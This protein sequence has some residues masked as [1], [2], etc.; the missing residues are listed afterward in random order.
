VTPGNDAYREELWP[1]AIATA[2][3]RGRGRR[4]RERPHRTGLGFPSVH[5]RSRVTFPKR[6]VAQTPSRLWVGEL[7]RTNPR[8]EAHRP[9]PYRKI[10]GNFLRTR[11]SISEGRAGRNGL[12]RAVGLTTPLLGWTSRSDTDQAC[13]PAQ[14]GPSKREDLPRTESRGSTDLRSGTG[15]VGLFVSCAT[16]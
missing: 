16:E 8:M 11:T 1:V 7:F 2:S 9:T 13:L 15:F 14:L 12:S 5:D 3:V 6:Q 4:V 10:S